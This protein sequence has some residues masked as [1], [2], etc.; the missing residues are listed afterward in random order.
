MKGEKNA[1][2]QRRE[3]A[4]PRGQRDYSSSIPCALIGRYQNTLD[5]TSVF[6][7]MAWTSCL[8]K[9]QQSKVCLV[10]DASLNTFQG[11][12][13]KPSC[14]R[15]SSSITLSNV[16]IHYLNINQTAGTKKQLGCG[17]SSKFLTHST[18]TEC[19]FLTLHFRLKGVSF[20]VAGGTE[21]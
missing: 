8:D 10:Q 14:A 18:L 16:A 2:E 13:K 4:A 1:N 12:I 21:R 9:S 6:L 3:G 19:T 7:Q 15:C 5:S 20:S 11:N 17:Y